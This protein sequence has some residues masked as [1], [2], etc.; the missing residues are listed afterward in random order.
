MAIS[1][2][3]KNN[4]KLYLQLMEEVKVRMTAFNKVLANQ[5]GL[6]EMLVLENGSLQ[7]RF[8]C[9][10]ISLACLSAHGDYKLAR[11][12]HD[13]YEP[14][15]ILKTLEKLNSAFYPQPV[16]HTN[17]GKNHEVIGMSNIDHLTKG[18]LKKLWGLTGC[19]LHRTPISKFYSK[20]KS[21]LSVEDMIKWANKIV[22]LLNEH[23]IVVEQNKFSL[24]VSLKNQKTGLSQATFLRF[25]VN[26][27]QVF[28]DTISA[29]PPSARTVKSSN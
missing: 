20:K 26:D 11:A 29:V 4:A 12:A 3:L 15:K 2:T 7:L 19:V 21:Q 24:L 5:E 9:E 17:Q 13:T 25:D 18:D 8:M 16:I 22:N 6:S 28:V 14:G 1:K 23:I 10:I 27:E